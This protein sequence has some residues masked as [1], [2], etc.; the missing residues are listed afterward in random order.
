MSYDSAIAIHLQDSSSV[1]PETFVQMIQYLH[2]AGLFQFPTNTEDNDGLND[3]RYYEY[4]EEQADEDDDYDA[5]EEYESL[6]SL[7]HVGDFISRWKLAYCGASFRSP[8]DALKLLEKEIGQCIDNMVQQENVMLRPS[9]KFG[10]HFEN[11]TDP[12]RAI[13]K[14]GVFT[15]ILAIM[16][17]ITL[18]LNSTFCKALFLQTFVRQWSEF[19][20][21]KR[22]L[23]LF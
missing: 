10:I 20:S 2:D 5:I 6:E 3:L 1:T 4:D 19:S 12:V 14:G 11:P 17:Q 15:W 9:S 23:R 7:E 16:C 22:S 13:T 8:T 18:Y 21:V